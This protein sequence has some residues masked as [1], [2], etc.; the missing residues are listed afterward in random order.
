MSL[1]D[2]F[3]GAWRR[4]GLIIDGVRRVDYSDVLWLQ[5]S[6]WF[7]DIRT[8]IQPGTGPSAD[9]PH[10]E[11]AGELSFAGTT[12]LLDGELR[13]NHALDSRGHD[14]PPDQS[15]VWWQD[16][17][18]VESAT[19]QWQGRVVPFVEEWGYLGRDGLHGVGRDGYIR[20]E[21][22]GLAVE[23]SA[24]AGEF[25]AVKYQSRS[26]VWVETGRVIGSV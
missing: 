22:A 12:D 11:F 19:F 25:S 14:A 20:V 6:D 13:W 23:V 21:A 1:P 17:L 10:I 9:D 5:S 3:L 8:H 24:G 15:P 4:V 26:G 2:E 7:A 18:L 16:K